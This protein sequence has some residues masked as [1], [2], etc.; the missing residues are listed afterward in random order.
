MVQ[1]GMDEWG[2]M[3][4]ME[5]FLQTPAEEYFPSLRSKAVEPPPFTSGLRVPQ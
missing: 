4:E 2:R 5:Q 3:R 1:E